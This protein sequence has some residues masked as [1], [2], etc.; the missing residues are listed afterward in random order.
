MANVLQRPR[1]E[2]IEHSVNTRQTSEI[3]TGE[4]QFI[5]LTANGW[6]DT[7]TFFGSQELDKTRN[8]YKS[9][10][11][12][13]CPWRYI[14]EHDFNR[15]PQYLQNVSC[16]QTSCTH[17]NTP[18]TCECREVG[19]TVQILKRTQCVDSMGNSSTGQQEWKATNIIVNVACVP[20]LIHI[21]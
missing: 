20:R 2:A 4:Q 10:D 19:Y 9:G 12:T 15:Y 6:D 17:H 8:T 5:D 16:L 21:K 3:Q 7:N 1:R 13:P 18:G 11:K 14:A